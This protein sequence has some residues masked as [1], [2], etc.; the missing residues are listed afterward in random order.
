[1]YFYSIIKFRLGDDRVRHI[2][3][4]VDIGTD[5]TKVVVTELYKG[6]LNLLA[7][8]S[9]KSEGIKK[10]LITDVNKASLSLKKAI[11]EVQ[12][13]L[14]F[15]IKKVLVNVPSYFADFSKIE[16]SIK[17]A[18]NEVISGEHISKVLENAVS[19]SSFDKEIVSI[20][21][22]DFGVDSQTG[23]KD[24]KGFTGNT[25]SVRA[26]VSLVPKK[27]IYSVVSLIDSIGL[28]VSDISLNG[29]G[30]INAFKN[31]EIDSKLGAIVNIGYE[32]TNVSIYNKGIIIKNSIIGM[33][34]KNIDNDLSYMYKIDMALATR[35]KE[36]FAYAHRNYAN[37]VE[38]YNVNETDK[39][40]Q[41]EVTDVVM[42]RIEEIL[43]LAKKEINLLANRKMD[44][45]IITGGVS[46]M[47]GFS[48]ICEDVFGKDVR[49][50]TVNIIG[51]RNNKYSSAIGNVV[52]YINH[53]KL[54]GKINSA[55][56]EI[57][58]DLINVTEESML[59]KVFGYFFGDTNEE[60]M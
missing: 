27:N 4:S 42:S 10:G 23:I 21:P 38:F 46:N 12:E 54:L 34:G 43:T 39:I 15:R 20:I 45:V 60:E 37:K 8:S 16:G 58:R 1:M 41:Y 30:D 56:N 44:Y 9:T 14:G 24:P 32:T 53:L 33:G 49:L 3:T 57:G 17:I 29:I 2:Y 18:E 26:V 28:E 13:M 11:S 31:K 55:E 36:K 59:S 40:N 47:E 19:N 52:Y 51:I 6:K 25:L 50:G 22:I 48:S 35:V 5:T 7:A